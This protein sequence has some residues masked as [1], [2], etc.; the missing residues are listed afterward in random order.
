MSPKVSQEHKEQRRKQLLQ[1]AEEVF[2][3]HGYENTTMKHVMDKAGVSRGGLYQYFD[4]K[5]DLFEALIGEQQREIIDESLQAMI[6]EQG[7]CW[8]ALLMTF[9][10]EEKTASDTM[11]PLAPSKLEY[12]ITGRNEKRRREHAKE[13]YFHGF[14]VTAKIIEKGVEAG[15]FQPRFDPE[16]IARFII[17][18]VDGLAVDHAIL[19]SESI[20][21]K[22]QTQLL[23]EYLK[24]GLNVKE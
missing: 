9:L 1:A 13:R 4:N 7:S 3:E 18:Y 23:I 22:E 17:S 16:V 21:L 20:K 14:R 2:I 19:D 11:D 24:W 15:E 8:D 5:E 6:E 10:G 12:F